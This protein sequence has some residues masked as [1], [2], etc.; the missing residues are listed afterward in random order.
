[1]GMPSEKNKKNDILTLILKIAAVLVVLGVIGNALAIRY[2]ENQLRELI[3][4]SVEKVKV[5]RLKMH[6]TSVL[7][8]LFG[9]I[10]KISIYAEEV[11]IKDAP[12]IKNVKASL[13]D[14][15]GSF[16]GVDKVGA[17]DVNI[18]LAEEDVN[19]Y[20]RKKIN[21]KPPTPFLKLR[22]NL[23]V[24]GV[25]AP[26]IKMTSPV[27]VAGSITIEDK[28]KLIFIPSKVGILNLVIKGDL[29]KMVSRKLNP[30]LDLSNI[31]LDV[32]INNFKVEDKRIRVYG[33]IGLKKPLKFK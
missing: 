4:T 33:E 27:T 10:G 20:V 17:T 19:E 1:M 21:F 31:D 26:M 18:V 30:V 24:A 5:L 14:I 11:E 6:N 15:K 22:D 32:K 12:K 23:V 16:E 7:N 2:F 9:R 29:P 13:R 8:I 28:N 25:R 3:V